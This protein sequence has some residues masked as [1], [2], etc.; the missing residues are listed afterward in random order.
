MPPLTFRQ[1]RDAARSVRGTEYGPAAI[2]RLRGERMGLSR[3]RPRLAVLLYLAAA[4]GRV[5]W[6]SPTA[7]AV[8]EPPGA[9]PGRV[10]PGRHARWARRIELGW[11][12]LRDFGPFVLL[13]A[14]L[15][16][17]L[18]AGRY[19]QLF[20]AIDGLLVALYALALVTPVCIHGLLWIV[21]WL[22][23]P[24]RG[25]RASVD[26]VLD[27]NWSIGLLHVK[28]PAA[29]ETILRD[30]QERA[31]E[32]AAGTDYA[33]GVLVCRDGA[34]TTA[35]ARVAVAATT[36]AAAVPD[37]D[38][39]MVVVRNPGDGPPTPVPARVPAF[40]GL[41]L[42][43]CMVVLAGQAWIIVDQGPADGQFTAYPD[44]LAWL[45]DQAWLFG[46]LGTTAPAWVPARAYGVLA[47]LLGLIAIGVL[48][49]AGWLAYRAH[50]AAAAAGER[51]VERVI[52][53]ADTGLVFLSYRKGPHRGLVKALRRDL[54]GRLGE[55]RVFM[56]YRSIP[57]G[58][59]SSDELRDALQRCQVLLAIIH[60]GW[61][62]KLRA[63][64][65]GRDWVR[66]EIATALELGKVLIAVYFDEAQRLN[67][68]DLPADIRELALRQD[69][70]VRWQSGNL[71]DDLDRL[72]RKVLV[73]AR[74][75]G[76]HSGQVT[77]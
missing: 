12:Y 54:A 47:Q 48:A 74:V 36:T 49:K 2:R 71:D 17:A 51:A 39:A 77:G 21:R 58:S 5:V 64:R 70:W 29:V 76:T 63:P 38:E 6:R 60:K 1:C 50:Q 67:A 75:P 28:N 45:L 26:R 8:L 23:G 35:A 9:D 24:R 66:C 69:C 57:L 34:V 68:Q 31:V 18:F 52:A 44:V 73:A 59:R 14:A 32:L 20:L 55:D 62:D 43:A 7:F 25:G 46:D 22:R 65:T 15:P 72:A 33:G 10:G 11:P 53:E 27:R 40:L 42:G 37:T 30:C 16:L 3:P 41:F 61:M 56:D 4:Q 13:I 19:A